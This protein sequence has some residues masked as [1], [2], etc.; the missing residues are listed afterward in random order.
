MLDFFSPPGTSASGGVLAPPPTPTSAGHEHQIMHDLQRIANELADQ[1]ND[2][3]L[4]VEQQRFVKEALVARI[5]DLEA[6]VAGA[7]EAADAPPS[8]APEEKEGAGEE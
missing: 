8:D 7:A 3:M 1:L 4:A 2:A 6:R 5:R